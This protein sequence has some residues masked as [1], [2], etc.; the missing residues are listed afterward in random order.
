M[1]AGPLAKTSAGWSPLACLE[2]NVQ[3]LLGCA[4]SE[5]ARLAAP[6]I[7]ALGPHRNRSAKAGDM[8]AAEAG[9]ITSSG[10]TAPDGEVVY[11]RVLGGQQMLWTLS[12]EDKEAL[13]QYLNR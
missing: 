9:S 5:G 12:P 8:S 7:P 2:P 4:L 10:E 13:W 6:G 11:G 3:R 1:S